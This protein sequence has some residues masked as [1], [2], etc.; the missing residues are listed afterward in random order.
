MS[1]RG[2]IFI[3]FNRCLIGENINQPHISK[4]QNLFIAIFRSRFKKAVYGIQSP[5]GGYQ[6]GQNEESVNL[7]TSL[8]IQIL[9]PVYISLSGLKNSGLRM[10]VLIILD[11]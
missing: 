11:F 8:N 3:Y 7:L 6:E 1:L 2:V 9:R 4:F 5:F 10:T